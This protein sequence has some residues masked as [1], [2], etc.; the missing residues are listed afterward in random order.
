MRRCDNYYSVARMVMTD[1]SSEDE[2]SYTERMML[3][4][5]YNWDQ[6]NTRELLDM[7]ITYMSN[8][9]LYQRIK[10]V[11]ATRPHI[12]NKIEAKALR[13]QKAKAQRNR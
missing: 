3:R 9:N 11:L 4:E 10:E 2:P 5:D 12:P 13:Q 7:R 1:L 6:H 8:W